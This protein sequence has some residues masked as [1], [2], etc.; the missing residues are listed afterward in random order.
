MRVVVT[1][2]ASGIGRATALRFARE[3]AHILLTDR[4]AEA[5]EDAAAEIRALGGKAVTLTAD[6]TDPSA[7]AA[8]IAAAVEGFGGIEVVVSNAGINLKA[9]LAQCS[10]EDWD[11]VQAVNTRA[12]WLLG[13]AARPHLAKTAGALIATTSVAGTNP[14]PMC[15]AYSVSKAAQIMLIR[16]MALEWGP[17]GIRANCVSPGS[18]PTGMSPERYA[19]EERRA[20][21][22]ARN[23]LGLLGAPEDIAEAIFYLAGPQARFISG[24]EL[25]V[26]GGMQVTLAQRGAAGLGP[27]A[28]EHRL[29]S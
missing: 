3:G 29:S 1:G 14:T 8:I 2:A 10:I 12:T 17:D 18:I 11:T 27:T 26:D 20:L 5:L 24:S 6:L 21:A 4:A 19:T 15:G 25:V 16:Q 7:P 28:S 13:V 23:P 9:S 22:R